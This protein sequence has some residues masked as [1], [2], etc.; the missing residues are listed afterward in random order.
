[1]AQARAA[2]E[3]VWGR[4]SPVYRECLDPR[5]FGLP[6]CAKSRAVTLLPHF[7]APYVFPSDTS[8]SVNKVDTSARTVSTSS[9]Q[10]F[11]YDHLILAPGGKP[12]RLPIP[13]KDLQ[14]VQTMRFV[15]DTKAITSKISKDTD[16]VI[17]GTSFIGM[18]VAAAI[19]KKEP[20]SVTLVGVDAIPFEAILGKEIGTAIM[21]VRHASCA[22]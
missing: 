2:V 19:Q 16:V 15:E 21:E 6:G 7:R 8:Q 11:P 12:K 10:S 5:S 14:G 1:V 13:G 4:L 9:G 17:I 3:R 20:K 18:E 22:V